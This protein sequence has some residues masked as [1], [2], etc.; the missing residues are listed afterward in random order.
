[1]L[2][3]L[4]LMKQVRKRGCAGCTRMF[5]N[6]K[7]LAHDAQMRNCKSKEDVPFLT[8]PRLEQQITR[9]LRISVEITAKETSV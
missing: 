8:H 5:L 7:T 4:N 2:G 3:G 9:I 6:N 1:M